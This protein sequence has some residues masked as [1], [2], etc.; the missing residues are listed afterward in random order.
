VDLSALQAQL[1]RIYAD[2]ARRD[3]ARTEQ[4]NAAQADLASRIDNPG[5]FKKVVSSRYFQLAI[6]TVTTWITTQ[7]MTKP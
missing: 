4:I 3:D 7:Q 5:W 1:E 2:L 6:A